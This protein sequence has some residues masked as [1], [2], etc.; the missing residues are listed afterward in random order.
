[1]ISQMMGYCHAQNLTLDALEGVMVWN[2]SVEKKME[3][4][5]LREPAKIPLHLLPLMRLYVCA[6]LFKRD[7]EKLSGWEVETG[8]CVITL[9]HFTSLHVRSSCITFYQNN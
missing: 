4:E 3:P 5:R 9:I 2:E 8:G 6:C 1:M 7:K